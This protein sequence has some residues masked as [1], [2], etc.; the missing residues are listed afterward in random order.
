MRFMP[1]VILCSLALTLAGGAPS[2]PRDD[3]EL[4]KRPKG[5]TKE[6]VRKLLAQAESDVQQL[7]EA[8]R[9]EEKRRADAVESVAEP[10]RKRARKVIENDAVLGERFARY[11]A[12]V[13]AAFE[14][15]LSE[16][17]Q[18]ARLAK[19]R[20][21][22]PLIA[23]I[24]QKAGFDEQTYRRDIEK[25][26]G[27]RGRKSSGVTTRG[28]EAVIEWGEL[29]S[30]TTVEPQPAETDVTP[31]GVVSESLF[32]APFSQKYTQKN[33]YRYASAD[34][35]NGRYD[36]WA[37]TRFLGGVKNYAGIQQLLRTPNGA[38]SA[39]AFA[40]IENGYYKTHATSIGGSAG[41]YGYTYL[42]VVGLNKTLC[43]KK[44]T[45]P[46][47]YAPLFWFDGPKTGNFNETLSCGFTSPRGGTDIVVRVY[48][49]SS[50]SVGG[51]AGALARVKGELLTFKLRFS[52]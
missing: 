4:E 50:V 38:T 3:L 8:E 5:M 15:D 52:D 26:L 36:A 37:E 40:T 1:I 32:D 14:T 30:F 42:R 24:L 16:E 51:G 13:K 48:A 11:E 17:E 18:D 12:D 41:A 22:K 43:A 31:R 20:E 49:M 19:I 6:N 7:D 10:I 2:Q 44:I 47:A 33:G 46:K 27:L 25:A 28:D 34:A 35:S 23:E 21:H 29:G 9:A 45:H 39:Q